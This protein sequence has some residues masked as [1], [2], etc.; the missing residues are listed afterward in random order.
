MRKFVISDL[1]GN[2]EVYDSIIGYLENVSLVDDVE[3]YINGD[4]IDRGL[5]GYRMLEDVIERINGKGNIKIH[6]LGGNHELMMYQALKERKP[7]GSVNPWSNWMNNGGW[8][9][10]GELDS[11]E[12][13]AEEKIENIKSFLGNLKI[14]K[15][16]NEVIDGNNILLVHAKAPEI[17]KDECDMFIKDNNK[18]VEDSVWTREEIRERFLFYVGDVI[19][20]NIIGKEGY[21]TIKG[22]TPLKDKKGFAYNKEQNFIN[23]DGGCARY[24]CGDFKCDHVPL[25]EI[26]N[27]LLKIIV[28]NHNNQI[29]DGYY[30]DGEIRPMDELELEV[31]DM[32]IDHRYDDCCE[33]NKQLIKEIIELD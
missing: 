32:F 11:L 12:E 25:V 3:L 22:H 33:K 5:D 10:E 21:M 14:Y 26:K 4:L 8:V 7:G 28:F 29:I 20:Y 30:F 23:I 17:I 16:F 1:H 31:N 19:G 24:A 6:Y 27:Y 2:G 18:D 15:R 13:N 9:I